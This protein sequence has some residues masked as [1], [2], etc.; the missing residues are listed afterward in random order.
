MWMNVEVFQMFG[1]FG[2][3]LKVGQTASKL[4]GPRLFERGF[5]KIHSLSNLNN[6]WSNAY[7]EW[8]QKC[9]LLINTR[10]HDTTGE[11]LLKSS[12]EGE[13]QNSISRDIWANFSAFEN[14][15]GWRKYF[16]DAISISSVSCMKGTLG[17]H[18]GQSQLALRDRRDIDEQRIHA[19]LSEISSGY[20]LFQWWFIWR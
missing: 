3:K 7:F 5:E 4:L 14:H 16:R 15:V 2:S 10:E 6:I 17:K 1:Y 13:K 19:D 9:V 8:K 11:R 18:I 12:I 20:F